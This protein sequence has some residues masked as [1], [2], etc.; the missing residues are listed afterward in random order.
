MTELILR[1]ENPFEL[2]QLLPILQ[3]LKIK[4]QARPI[5]TAPKKSRKKD[6]IIAKI[7]VGAFNLPN[8]EAFMLDFELSRQDNPLVGRT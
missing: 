5:K 8:L 7:Q 4:Y 1:I 3:Q 2:E 6:A